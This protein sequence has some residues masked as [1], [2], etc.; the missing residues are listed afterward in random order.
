MNKAVQSLMDQNKVQQGM[1]TRLN[2]RTLQITCAM[3]KDIDAIRRTLAARTKHLAGEVKN[4]CNHLDILQTS[5]VDMLR[6]LA[7]LKATQLIGY[8]SE[9]EGVWLRE[10]V[11]FYQK[12]LYRLQ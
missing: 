9:W 12:Y 6:I 1:I 10:H 11:L 4:I 5:S 2:N 8:A 7:V 3:L